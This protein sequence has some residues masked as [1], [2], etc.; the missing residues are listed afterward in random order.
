VIDMKATPAPPMTLEQ[1]LATARE[2]EPWAWKHQRFAGALAH[3]FGVQVAW[4]TSRCGT[5]RWN[6]TW[7]TAPD[8]APRCDDCSAISVNSIDT[9]ARAIL[10]VAARTA[11]P[12]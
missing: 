5:A 3:Q 8:D 6:V 10:A 12:A 2:T 1:A 9:V 7:Y 4:M 11:V